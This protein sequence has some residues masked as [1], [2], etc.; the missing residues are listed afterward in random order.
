[1]FEDHVPLAAF[2]SVRLPATS[3]HITVEIRSRTVLLSDNASLPPRAHNG[4]RYIREG[5]KEDHHSPVGVG[6]GPIINVHRGQVLKVTWQ[7]K[8]G[9][10]PPMEPGD[11]P[12]LEMPPVNP[13]PMTFN[14]DMWNQMNPSVGVVTHLHGAV[15][16]PASDG[17]PLDPISF[18]GNPYGFPTSRTYTYTNDQR[19]NMLWFHDHGMDNTSIQVHAGLAGLYF[20]RDS[21]DEDVLSLIG[22]AEHSEIPLVIQDRIVGCNFGQ[23]D[24]WAGVPTT[25]DPKTLAQDF[26]RP[27]YLGDTIFVDGRPWPTLNVKRKVYRLRLLNGSNART[28]ALALINSAGWASMNALDQPNV[29]YSDCLRIIGNDGGLLPKSVRLSANDYILLAPAER[30]DLLIDFTAVDPMRVPRLKLVNLAVRSLSLGEWAEAIF[31]TQDPINLPP[32]SVDHTP[33][34]PSSVLDVPASDATDRNILGYVGGIRQASIMQFCIE[35]GHAASAPSAAAI[36]AALAKYASGDGFSWNGSELTRSDPGKPIAA[37]RFIVLMNNSEG[38]SGSAQYTN[39]DW[40]DTQIWEMAQ[41]A[42]SGDPFQIAFDINLSAAN[43]PAGYPSSLKVYYVA[44]SSF[45]DMFPASKRID[46]APFGYAP[47]NTNVIKPKAG[48]Y[49][50]W[51]VANLGNWQPT[52]THPASGIPD[53]HPFHMHLVN[54]VVTNRWRLDLTTNQFQH[55]Y[56]SRPLDLDGVSR[57]DTVRVQANELLELL[58]YFP[59]GYTG[60]YP[61]HCHIVEHEDMG[62]MS[63]FEVI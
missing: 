59:P 63:H 52:D 41:T 50:R 49:E 27:E 24:Y 20:I 45:F 51:Y 17:W 46:K 19:A 7:N 38:K 30:L 28:Y 32:T 2:D 58:V 55:T 34:V 1:M 57:H 22:D 39:G 33:V 44:R 10:M 6:L 9:S 40:R 29:W 31:Q 3:H 61:F 14:N 21:S 42:V 54:F 15:V 48:T 13:L 47:L 12:T 36:D 23:V 26:E 62:M 53:M 25:T 56:R 8:L 60:V 37:N 5:S 4:W 43:P 16:L 35:G 11:G 18:P